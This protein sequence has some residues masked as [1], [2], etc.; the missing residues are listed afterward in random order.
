MNMI[1]HDKKKKKIVPTDIPIIWVNI[2]ET[3]SDSAVLL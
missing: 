2:V 3:A 1:L